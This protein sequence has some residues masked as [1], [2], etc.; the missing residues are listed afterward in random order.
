[1]ARWVIAV[2]LAGVVLA[3]SGC[4]TIGV[5]T[6]GIPGPVPMYF[7]VQ[8][9]V[10]EHKW[11]DVPFSGVAD[12]VLLPFTT[13]CYLANVVWWKSLDENEKAVLADRCPFPWERATIKETQ[14]LK[15]SQEHDMKAADLPPKN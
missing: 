4:G 12:T 11:L 2:S 14:R 10:H 3:Q 9:D 5:A 7:G 13:A 6:C 15:E 8:A 1:M